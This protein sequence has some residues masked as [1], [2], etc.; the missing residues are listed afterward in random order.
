MHGDD[1]YIY[2]ENGRI[3]EMKDIDAYL[4]KIGT[5]HEDISFKKAI[6]F[7]AICLS[8]GTALGVGFYVKKN[9]KTDELLKPAKTEKYQIKN[10]N[11]VPNTIAYNEVLVRG[12]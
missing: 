12:R 2:K 10:I 9:K 1:F 11:S 3:V 5:W 6:I 8:L 4:K 7:L